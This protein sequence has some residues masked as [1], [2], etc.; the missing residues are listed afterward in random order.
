MVIQNTCQA[1]EDL[2]VHTYSEA[3]VVVKDIKNINMRGNY[4][5]GTAIMA[6]LEIMTSNYQ[7]IHYV[8]TCFYIKLQN[9]VGGWNM[10]KKFFM[11]T[12]V[13]KYHPQVDTNHQ[14]DSKN[15]YYPN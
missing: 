6:Y 8:I 4:I 5:N 15:N 14:K 1:H 11:E 12:I 3:T 7:N 13:K 9:P 2:Q 10:V